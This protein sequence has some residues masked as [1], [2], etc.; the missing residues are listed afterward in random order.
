MKPS[1]LAAVLTAAALPVLAQ[2]PNTAPVEPRQARVEV[3]D[4]AGGAKA[5][6]PKKASKAAKSSKSSKSLKTAKKSSKK[7]ARK[8]PQSVG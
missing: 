3:S 7:K 4:P 1:I 5:T 2:T 8:K 6:A